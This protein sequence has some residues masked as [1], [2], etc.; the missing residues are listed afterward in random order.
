M[1]LCVKPAKPQD[2]RLLD[3]HSVL[4]RTIDSADSFFDAFESV[5]KARKAKG[6]PTD[7]EQDLLRAALLF[8][9][10]GLDAMAKQL[11]R[12]VLGLVQDK[13]PGARQQ[14]MD[15]L[16]ARLGRTAP[17]DIKLLAQAMMADE[18]REHI[19]GELIRELT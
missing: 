12:D 10:A 6:T 15:F 4:S 11:I 9:A 8:A 5:R 16:I 17:V 7:H 19:R 18:P 13:E 3:A 1:G 14:F 2:G